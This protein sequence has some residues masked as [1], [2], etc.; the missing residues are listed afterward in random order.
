MA[1]TWLLAV[2]CWMFSPGQDAEPTSLKCDACVLAAMKSR[3]WHGDVCVGSAVESC[4]I[5]FAL[6]SWCLLGHRVLAFW[7]GKTFSC[8]QGLKTHHRQVPQRRYS[9][10]VDFVAAAPCT[11]L[12]RCMSLRSQWLSLQKS[13]CRLRSASAEKLWSR[14]KN[15]FCEVWQLEARSWNEGTAIWS[16]A[17][18]AF[19]WFFQVNCQQCGRP[20][21]DSEVG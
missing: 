13:A 8:A 10:R 14:I 18:A 19:A 21:R 4:W 2:S 16:L 11:I 6:H 3:A 20:F 17:I 7:G 9:C 1:S 15:C 5:L 12:C